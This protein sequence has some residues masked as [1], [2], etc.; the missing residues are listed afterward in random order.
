MPCLLCSHLGFI[1]GT[2]KE[3][4]SCKN[5]E[6]QLEDFTCKVCTSEG[7]RFTWSLTYN[8]NPVSRHGSDVPGALLPAGILVRPVGAAQGP[9]GAVDLMHTFSWNTKAHTQRKEVK[10]V[11]VQEKVRGN[12]KETGRK[13]TREPKGDREDFKEARSG[14]KFRG[15]FTGKAC[16]D[17]PDSC[18]ILHSC[19]IKDYTEKNPE[20]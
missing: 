3:N 4:S 2:W 12:G 20:D 17:A 1:N 15:N 9:A 6:E 5:E 11:A 10:T 16:T 13:E 18:T 8:F 19:I 7:S 14:H